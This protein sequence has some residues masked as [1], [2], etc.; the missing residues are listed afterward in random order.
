MGL[1]R[2]AQ[3]PQGLASIWQDVSATLE[4]VHGAA[5]DD[6][7]QRRVR[8]HLTQLTG[9]LRTWL[10]SHPPAATPAADVVQET[11][12]LVDGAALQRYI[13]SAVPERTSASSPMHSLRVW[14]M[15]PGVPPTGGGT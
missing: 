4:R 14:R 12:G 7:A 11:L 9:S 2:L 8:D 1:P 3:H 10:R 15:R 6:V 5:D 13:K